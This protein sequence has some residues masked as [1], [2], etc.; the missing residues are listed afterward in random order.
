MKKTQKKTKRGP[1]R[2]QQALMKEFRDNCCFE[3]MGKDEVSADDP[4]GFIRWWHKNIEWV[5][6][7]VT[8]TDHLA[9]HY[10]AKYA[11]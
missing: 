1:S 7:T 9:R 5:R 11:E 8:D 4:Q 10:E 6:D 2:E 3:F